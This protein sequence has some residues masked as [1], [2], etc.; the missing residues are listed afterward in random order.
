M[1]S[2]PQPPGA[3]EDGA[4]YDPGPVPDAP[5]LV[6][7]RVP[8]GERVVNVRLEAGVWAALEEIAM[9][10]DMTLNEVCW[11]VAVHAARGRSLPAALRAYALRYFRSAAKQ[12]EGADPPP[13]LGTR[14]R[15][16]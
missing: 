7:R 6:Q 16:S 13:P 12:P 10:E 11:H 5:A 3:G 14:G 2:I 15:F 8:N 9:R 4:P 1:P